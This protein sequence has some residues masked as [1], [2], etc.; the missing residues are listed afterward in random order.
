MFKEYSAQSIFIIYEDKDTKYIKWAKA[1]WLLK[2]AHPIVLIKAKKT[3][4]F[5]TDPLNWLKTTLGTSSLKPGLYVPLKLKP[6]L[7]IDLVADANQTNRYGLTRQ[8]YPVI[9]LLDVLSTNIEKVDIVDVFEDFTCNTLDDI[10][11]EEVSFMKEKL[12]M[13]VN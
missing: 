11:D 2:S 8:N 7:D 10:L 1:F 5:E 4:R 12:L 3:L 9:C 13:G 6:L